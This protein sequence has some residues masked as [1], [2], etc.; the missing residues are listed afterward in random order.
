MD[1]EKAGLALG[2]GDLEGFMALCDES[3]RVDAV[4]GG[5][6]ILGRMGVLTIEYMTNGQGQNHLEAHS[7][8]N[9]SDA[10]A[11]Y[12]EMVT[13][14]RAAAAEVNQI[15]NLLLGRDAVTATSNT[16]DYIPG[17]WTTV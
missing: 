4:S 14:S 1:V 8:A 5:V 12:A 13:K 10:G 17:N 9:E 15:A 2:S 7:H 11:C 3:E 6:L 16:P